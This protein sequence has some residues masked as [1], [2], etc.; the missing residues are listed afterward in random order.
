MK[1]R[2]IELKNFRQIKNAKLEFSTDDIKN[3]TIVMGNNGTGKTTLAQAFTWCLYGET[4]FKIKKVLN[5]D[6]ENKLQEGYGTIVCVKIGLEHNK[7]PYE[8]I[9]TQNCIKKNNGSMNYENTQI[10]IMTRT[11]DGITKEVS[12]WE[13]EIN[14]ILPKEMARYFFFDG[15]RIE[16]MS[17]EIQGGKKS[18]EFADAVRGLLGLSVMISAMDHLNPSY[19]RSVV[20]IYEA[21]YNES[22]NQKVRDY[23][24]KFFKLKE[25]LKKIELR[26]KEITSEEESA[27]RIIKEK[28]EELKTYEETRELQKKREK[29]EAEIKNLEQ[30]KDK[31]VQEVLKDINDH[32]YNFMLNKLIKDVLE[33]LKEFKYEEKTIPELN[34]KLI[35]YLLEQ[36]R[37]ICGREIKENSLEYENLKKLLEYLPPKSLGTIISEFTEKSK[38]KLK[39]KNNFYKRVIERNLDIL[40]IEDNIVT[41]NDTLISIDRK[42]IEKDIKKIIANLVFERNNAQVTLKELE[43]EKIKLFEKRGQKNTD[44]K[45]YESAI[46]K[47][48]LANKE[49]KKI[50]IYKAYAIGAY[51]YLKEKL[52]QSEIKLR[53][54]LEKEINS[55]FKTIYEGGLSLDID[56]NYGI[57]VHVSNYETETSTAQSISVIF[58]FISG[59]IK[60]AREYQNSENKELISEPYPLVMDAPLS[61]FD[62][63]RIKKVCEILPE[64]AEQIII[65]IKDTDGDLARENLKNKIGKIYSL[66]KIDEFDTRLK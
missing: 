29:Y 24:E 19:K 34:S 48:N 45:R 55:I 14:K 58:A 9:R 60:L 52:D 39:I 18:D 64:I 44:I 11:K 26:L 6:I 1:I 37:C 61:A 54:L 7:T 3:V 5:K 23:S 10:K 56:N 8:I 20:G 66:E 12:D 41:H 63:H 30:K 35:N 33:V 2:Y 65:F 16:K 47:A 49:N 17:K 32:T 43:N 62:K 50:E 22:S 28:N 57:K 59:I 31:K 40:E 25:D 13:R 46:I 36:H 51:N 21:S 4:S 53:T 15:E 27:K 42:L 38:E